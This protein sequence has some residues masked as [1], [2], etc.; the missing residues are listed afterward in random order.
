MEFFVSPR[1]KDINQ[2]SREAP[3]AS[4]ERVRAAVRQFKK[5]Q[6]GI[7]V[8]V[9]LRQGIYHFDGSYELTREDSGTVDAPVV[10]RSAAGERAIVSG[11][12][13]IGRFTPVKDPS[14]LR[15]LDRRVRG[16]ILQSNLTSFGITDYGDYEETSWS[17]SRGERLELF[18]KDRPMTLARWPNKGF[19]R[20]ADVVANEN[21][22]GHTRGNRGGRIVCGGN[23]LQRWKR[24]KDLRLHGYWF[25]DWAEQRMAVTDIDP[26][27]KT[28]ALRNPETHAFGYRK[29]QRFYAYNALCEL[30]EPGEWFLD[31]ETGILYFYPPEPL[32]EGSTVLSMTA[33]PL[34]K[35]TGASH[36]TWQ[37]VT[38]ESGRSDGL[39]I[40]GGRNARAV[41]CV[42]RN[43][44]SWAVRIA[45][46]SAH[47]IIGC[48]IY[49]TGEGGIV[50]DGGDRK[51]LRA[52]GHYA[53]NN[54]IH[55]YARWR[56]VYRPAISI[57]GV[58]NRAANNL[59]HDAPHMA[60]RFSGNEHIIERNEIH[61]VVCESFDAGA[62]YCGRD[63]SMQGNAIRHNYFH[64]IGRIADYHGVASVYLDDGHSGNTIFG[65]LF[66]KAGVPGRC[67]FGAVFVH[68]GRYNLIDNNVFVECEQVYNE[69]PWKNREWRRYWSTPP[70]V[71]RL[72]GDR[73]DVRK[74]PYAGKYPWLSGVLDDE[75]PNILTRNIVYK[76]GAFR[77]RGRQDCRDNLSRKDP[78]FM[79]ATRKDF[80][81]RN[82]SPAF[83]RGFERIPLG[84]IGLIDD[85][86]RASWPPVKKP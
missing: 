13:R 26:S 2:G 59:I 53:V 81:L 40:S 78:M 29:G 15:R 71:K 35:M 62:V 47:G 44:G 85:A 80:Q 56:R 86:T 70:Y 64:H 1:G 8:T 23:R 54:H 34:V 18:F 24:E 9:I 57:Y 46:G 63:P 73:I 12:R 79:D 27:N 22:E 84:N 5:Q 72:F 33:V 52:A 69:T 17:E 68:G 67:R 82:D 43:L 61:D 66:Y 74:Q 39:V 6:P 45:G 83:K 75:R 3:F 60:I 49:G 65:N 25:H 37:G 48:D 41:G 31:R 19:A 14:V 51:T 7:P 58:G 77:N 42:F 4:L 30:D 28:I 50:L 16:K 55:H 20:I 38:F 32:T 11:G 36:V 76:C 21:I 10:Y